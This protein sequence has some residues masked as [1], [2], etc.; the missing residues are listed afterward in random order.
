MFNKM[1]NILP[2]AY[3]SYLYFALCD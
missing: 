1:L 3:C 2:I